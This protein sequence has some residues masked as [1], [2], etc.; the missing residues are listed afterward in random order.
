VISKTKTQTDALIGK[1][2]TKKIKG[3]NCNHLFKCNEI[4]L[5]IVVVLMLKAPFNNILKIF[6]LKSK[7]M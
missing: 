3:S 1:I 5:K 2:R 4:G 6:Y 7:W